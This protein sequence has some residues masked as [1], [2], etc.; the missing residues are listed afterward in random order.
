MEKVCSVCK[1][2]KPL[3]AFNLKPDGKKGHAARCRSCQSEY[4]RDWYQKNKDHMKHR[5]RV[6]SLAKYGITVD[7][8]DDMLFK[9]NNCCAICGS[10]K[11]AAGKRLAV[12]HSHQT[13]AVRGLL[14]DECNTGL[15]KFKDDPSLLARA[16]EYLRD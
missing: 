5:M 3:D 7:D 15:G 11:G 8:Y 12:D 2:L 13:G 10:P 16:I 1:I 6:N 14:C 4:H 9:Q